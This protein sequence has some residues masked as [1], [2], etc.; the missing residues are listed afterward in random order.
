[1]FMLQIP[2]CV[3][4]SELPAASRCHIVTQFN[5]GI[6]DVIVASDEKFLDDQEDF[7]VMSD[8]KEE[9]KKKRR[10]KVDKDKE[11]SKRSKDKESGVS[12]GIDFQFVSNVINFDF[13]PDVDA[14]IHRVGRTARG[15][16]K[17][18]ALSLVAGKEIERLTLVETY[19]REQLEG[20]AEEEDEAS[21]TI[22]KPYKFK[23]DELEGFRY[24]ARDAWRA[25]T[26]IAVREARLKEIRA[27]LL[28]SDRL[29]GHFEENPR[30]A[31]VLRHDK[32][33]HT[34]RHQPHLRHV[35]DYIVPKALKAVTKKKGKAIG[36]RQPISTAKRKFEKN[37]TDPLKN[38][39]S[40]RS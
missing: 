38:L 9:P 31:V 24:R 3:L 36:K 39:S 28:N 15:N 32:A 40:K 12:R 8:D 22:F 13:P 33:L 5:Q 23:L 35:P 6:Y 17:G 16:N 29:R 1:M 34:V 27:E 25:V 37:R 4:N 19:F 26:K 14:Y 20:E 10:K 7:N 2:A 11:R 21:T 18:T 30:D